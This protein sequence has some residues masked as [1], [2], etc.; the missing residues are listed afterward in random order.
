MLREQWK[1]ESV[2]FRKMAEEKSAEA[3]KVQ[4][5]EKQT[6]GNFCA[7]HN[8][9]DINAFKRILYPRYQ[10][11]DL[12]PLERYLEVEDKKMELK[13]VLRSITIH[14]GKVH[15]FNFDDKMRRNESL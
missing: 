15:S 4:D 11:P 9:P 7:K 6:F 13:E 10:H 3:T 8:V 14:D 12:L 2:L 1:Q 5:L